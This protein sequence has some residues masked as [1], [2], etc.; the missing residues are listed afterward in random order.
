MAPEPGK[1]HAKAPQPPSCPKPRVEA[2]YLV[3]AD[4]RDPR[5]FAAGVEP[6]WSAD[7]TKLAYSTGRFLTIQGVDGNPSR[8]VIVALPIALSPPA[9]ISDPSWSPDGHQ[10][11]FSVYQTDS[12]FMGSEW[13]EQLYTVDLAAELTQ[14]DVKELT[15]TLAGESDHSP[16]YS[17]DGSEIAYAHWGPQPGIWLMNADGSNAHPIASVDGYSAGL[18]WSPDGRSLAFAL[19]ASP[20]VGSAQDGVYV[21]GADGSD[22]RRVS[23]T[24]DEFVLDR[25]TWSP[26]GQEIEFTANATSTSARALYAVRPDGTDRHVVLAEPWSVFQPAWQ[27]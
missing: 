19:K 16:V 3:G 20:F 6:A 2:I 15:A 18:S 25:P 11:V 4:G 26:N 24:D 12:T 1:H 7:G 22:L 13:R 9:A 27:P 14:L 17:P 5:W 10:I 23:S 8:D 21:V